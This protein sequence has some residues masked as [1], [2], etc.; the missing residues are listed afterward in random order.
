MSWNSQR[1]LVYGSI[2]AV[3]LLLVVGIPVYRL[4][5]NNAPNCFD[6]KQNQNETGVDCGGM[7]ERACIDEVVSI[8]VTMWSRAFPVA[9][10]IYNLVAYVQNPNVE[11]VAE[12]TKYIFRVYDKDN[13]LIGIREGY[14]DVPPTKT[15]PIFEQGFNAGERIPASTFF[16]FIRGVPWKK[17]EGTKPE[18]EVLDQRLSVSASGPRIDATLQNKTINQYQKVEVVAIVYDDT[19]NAMASSRTFIDI[20]PSNGTAPLIFTWPHIFPSPVSKIEII[21]KLPISLTL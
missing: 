6:K 5:F 15:F 10:G 3:F 18:L 17:Y 19:G 20:L 8:P 13:V 4:F 1:Q 16:E 14:A 11:Y 2:L 21:P 12:P 7:C 9:D